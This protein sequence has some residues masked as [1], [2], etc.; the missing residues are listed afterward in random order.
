MTLLEL[1]ASQIIR[2]SNIYIAGR[3]LYNLLTS[4]RIRTEL[5]FFAIRLLFSQQTLELE[6][7]QVEDFQ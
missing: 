1:H 3:K 6:Q 7:N 5:N 2:I 4:L